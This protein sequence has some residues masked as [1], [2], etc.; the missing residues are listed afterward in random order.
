MSMA[1]GEYVSVSS[2]PGTERA[3]RRREAAEL[4]EQPDAEFAELQSIYVGRGLT[5]ELARQVAEQMAG[6]GALDAISARTGGAPA[7]R[8]TLRVCTWGALAMALTALIGRLFGTV[9]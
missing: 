9:I 1:A 7:V 2:Q 4:A 3:D 5:P 6:H 8:A